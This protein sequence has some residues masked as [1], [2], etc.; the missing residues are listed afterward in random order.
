MFAQEYRLEGAFSYDIYDL[1]LTTELQ[2][3]T[4][5][6]E[7]QSY[8]SCL[9][10]IGVEYKLGKRFDIGAAFRYTFTEEATY[11]SKNSVDYDNKNRLTFDLGTNLKRFDNELKIKNRLRSQM[12][13]NDDGDQKFFIREKITFDYKLSNL[14]SPYTSLELHYQLQKN[15]IKAYRLYFGSEVAL[16][17]HKLD[18]FYILEANINTN[19]EFFY[20]LGVAYRFGIN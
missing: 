16:D 6:N 13:I 11:L 3:R 8:N 9:T 10:Q 1:G 4:G 20:V 17:K 14:W 5:F 7:N 15:E 19:T 12:N 18:F 2:G